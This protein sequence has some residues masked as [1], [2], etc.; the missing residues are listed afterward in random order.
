[1]TET[2]PAGVELTRALDPDAWSEYLD[3][4]SRELL[5][6]PVSIEIIAAP[7]PPTVEARG[8]ALQT[9][10]YDRREDVFE[11]AAARGGARAPRVLRH[12]V[13]HP[14]RIEVDNRTMLA[15]MTIAVDGADG[16]RT[17]IAIER[18]GD[19]SG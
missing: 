13:D 9:L 15:P 11:V 7:D 10:T 14:A 2:H 12:L 17:V 1:M 4:V 16:T 18:E 19:L 6:A 5:N 8:L 3:A